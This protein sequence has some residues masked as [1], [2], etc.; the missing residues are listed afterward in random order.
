MLIKSFP[1]WRDL[2]SPGSNSMSL[3]ESGDSASQA[4]KCSARKK[5]R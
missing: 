1:P 2:E 4:R 3:R 5:C